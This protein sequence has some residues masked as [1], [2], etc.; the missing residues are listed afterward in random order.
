MNPRERIRELI[1]TA[2]RGERTVVMGI[3]NVTP[4]S[5]FDGGRF[6]SPD[7]ALGQ[8]LRMVEEGA[9]IVDV[10][11]ESTRPGA[12]PLGSQEEL[13][14]ILP[15]I[16][17]I[18]RAAS[19]PISVDTYKAAVA[20]GAVGAG[21]AM[22]NDISAL[23][24]DPLMAATVAELDVPVC[25]MHLKGTPRDMQ[26]NPVYEDVV[27]EVRDWLARR[28]QAARSAGIREENIVIDPGFGFGKTAGHNLELLR[29]LREIAALGYPVVSGTSRKSTIGK[30]LGGLPV[31]ERLEGTAATVALSIAN[32]AAIV[33]VHD[34]KEMVRVARMT[35]AIVRGWTDA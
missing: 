30:V 21:A 20:Q 34:V 15:V 4:D 23:T 31:E 3:L 7:T 1:D 11:G 25:L 26:R 19:V 13:D 27:K 9:D 32:G 28:T 22:V 2:R 8:A 33:R 17:A 29:R 10:G 5:F 35:D 18:G 12:E 16:E 6:Q 24:F 14:R